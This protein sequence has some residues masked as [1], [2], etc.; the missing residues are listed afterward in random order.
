[1][2]E[3]TLAEAVTSRVKAIFNIPELEKRVTFTLLMIMVARVGIH[4]AV[5]GIN[6][7]A[8]KNFQQGNAIAPGWSCLKSFNFCFGNCPIY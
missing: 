8:F 5:P 1:V 2:I 7:E 6:T 4:I 3:L